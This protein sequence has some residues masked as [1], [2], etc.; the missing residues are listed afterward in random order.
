M[1]T[2]IAAA[3]PGA[4][5]LCPRQRTP[6]GAKPPSDSSLPATVP[7]SASQLEKLIFIDPIFLIFLDFF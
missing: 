2:Q 5:A 1:T 3:P 4:T 7:P 6:V